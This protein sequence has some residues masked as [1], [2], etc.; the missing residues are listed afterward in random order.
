MT[1]LRKPGWAMVDDNGYV[2]GFKDQVSGVESAL[3]RLNGTALVGPGGEVID[4]YGPANTVA[5]LG[6]SL[7]SRNT[8]DTGTQRSFKDFGVLTWANAKAGGRCSMVLNAGVSGE[9]T[10]EIL[11]RVGD[12]IAASPDACI[13]LAGKNDISQNIAPATAVANITSICQSLLSA[14]VRVILCTVPPYQTGN[15]SISAARSE[16]ENVINNGIK[17]IA[18]NTPGVTLADIA[19]DVIDPTSSPSVTKSGYMDTDNLHFS[20]KGARAAGEGALYDALVRV[21]QPIDRLP[22]SATDSYYVTATNNN[23]VRNPLFAGTGGTKSG[24]TGDIANN[25][26]AQALGSP[27]SAVG[28]LEARADGFGQDQVL[29]IVSTSASDSVLVAS[30]ASFHALLSAG[31][32]VQLFCDMSLES[33]TAVGGFTAY[34]YIT[35]AGTTYYYNTSRKTDTTADISDF[36]N[37]VFQTEELTLPEGAITAANVYFR[38][39]F[40]GAGG[41][42]F[43]FG[44]AAL[45]VNQ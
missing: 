37:Y 19:A 4:L 6:D 18:H 11:A 27:A 21:F 42:T 31:D 22:I 5:I 20:Q 39:W 10:D 36:A 8:D 30:A 25:W 32:R 7:L 14:G 28:S 35:I 2:V 12:V 29:T 23:M 17:S 38:I 43:K 41:A 40:T 15:A 3:A 26:F 44:R 16:A 1:I 34:L 13:V 9:R 45:R 24:V 33:A